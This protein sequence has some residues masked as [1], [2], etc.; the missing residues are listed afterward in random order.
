MYPIVDSGVTIRYFFMSPIYSEQAVTAQLAAILM[1]VSVVIARFSELDLCT[2][3]CLCLASRGSLGD[4][5][6]SCQSITVRPVL[7][8]V[9]FV[10]V[11]SSHRIR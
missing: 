6:V 10:S 4:S 3:R 1:T 2:T 7:K 5:E 11:I 8:H 9:D